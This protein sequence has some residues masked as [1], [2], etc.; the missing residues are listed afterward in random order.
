MGQGKGGA[1]SGGGVE[2]GQFPSSHFLWKI[3]SRTESKDQLK[4]WDS[5]MRFF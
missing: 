3:G 2:L 5:L 4:K 1:V